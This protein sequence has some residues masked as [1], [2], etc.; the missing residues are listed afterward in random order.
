MVK[1]V[2]TDR[3]GETRAVDCPDAQSLMM[4]LK[5]SGFD[6]MAICGGVLSCATCHVYLEPDAFARLPPPS[7]FEIDLLDSSDNYRPDSSRLSCQIAL[8]EA[9]DGLHVTLAP[10]D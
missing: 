4:G 6:I 5:S 7:E 8:A 1:V 9:L 3:D 2:V 10:E